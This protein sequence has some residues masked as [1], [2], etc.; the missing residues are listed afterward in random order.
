M[1]IDLLEGDKFYHSEKLQ[2]TKTDEHLESGSYAF[3]HSEKL[4]STK[5]EVLSGY[6]C[7]MFYHSEKLQ[8]TKTLDRE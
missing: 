7:P 5:T 3:Y 1:F 8:S 4:Q 6:R 2:S